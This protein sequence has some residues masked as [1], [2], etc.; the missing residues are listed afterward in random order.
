MIPVATIK[1]RDQV[2]LIV[3]EHG[4]EDESYTILEL[5]KSGLHRVLRTD[6]A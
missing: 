1:L 3:R 2:F 5:D 6:G 4:W